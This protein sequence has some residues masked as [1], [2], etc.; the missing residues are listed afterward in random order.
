MSRS[1]DDLVPDLTPLDPYELGYLWTLCRIPRSFRTYGERAHR[2]HEI[3]IKA[4]NDTLPGGMRDGYSVKDY[5]DACS[6]AWQH[7]GYEWEKAVWP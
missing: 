6:Q 7:N 1:S 3:A 4:L 2:A 5:S